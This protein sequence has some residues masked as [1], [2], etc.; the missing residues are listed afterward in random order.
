MRLGRTSWRRSAPT[1]IRS[2]I[3]R[4]RRCRKAPIRR[5]TRC[6]CRRR[7]CRRTPPPAASFMSATS[8]PISSIAST[9]SCCPT[10]SAASGKS[11]TPASSAAL[12]CL[13]AR[14]RRNMACAPRACWTSRP[15]RM[16]STIPAASASMAA[17]TAPSRRPSNMAARSEI[18]SIS[19]PGAI[20]A[21]ISESKI[22]RL[23][24]RRSTTAPRRKRA[25]P[26]FRRSSIPPAA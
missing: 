9:A 11:S 5:S 13:P 8:T 23:P 4:S 17:A 3:R 10:A 14:C 1:P 19:S 18:P 25:L 24:M 16:P 15:R 26:I 2:I 6:C 21:A 20:S 7:V 12:P 22:R